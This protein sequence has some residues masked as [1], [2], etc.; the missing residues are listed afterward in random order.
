[1]IHWGKKV[2]VKSLKRFVAAGIVCLQR[3]LVSAVNIHRNQ[4][5]KHVTFLGSNPVNE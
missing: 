2:E 5:T 4:D 1:M 3:L